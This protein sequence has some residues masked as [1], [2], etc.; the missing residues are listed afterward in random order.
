MANVSNPEFIVFA[1]P[2]F[3]SK[4]TKLLSALERFRYQKKKIIVF[5]PKIDTRY[6]VEEIVSHS[7]WTTPAVI[8]EDGAQMLEYLMKQAS[9]FD[10]VAVDEMFMIDGIADTLVWLFRNLGV[11]VIVS[12]LDISAT[13]KS[14]GEVEKVLTWATSVEKCSAVCTVCGADA[15]YTHKKAPDSQEI[16]VGGA[17]MYEP[18]CFSH[19]F[20]VNHQ[21]QEN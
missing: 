10:V 8:V 1:G 15:F 16:H 9:P 4:T 2:M 17:E 3:S 11:T 13:G 7:G 21:L 14:F 5:K 20:Q 6:A 18:R 12:T 19:H